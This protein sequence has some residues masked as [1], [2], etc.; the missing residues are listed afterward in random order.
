MKLSVKDFYSA[1]GLTLGLEET[2]EEEGME[3]MIKV[4]H[5]QRPGLSLAGYVKGKRNN[6]ILVFGRIEL[7]YL[8]DLKPE[9]R[10]ERL[11]G[12]VTEDNPLVI[13]ARGLTPPRELIK[14]CKELRV[15]LFKTEMHSMPLLTKLTM[16]LT[17]YFSLIDSVHGTLVEAYGIGVLIQGDSSVGKSEA[18]LGLIERGHRLISDDVVKIRT[19]EGVGV[20]G[21]GHELNKH[22]LELRGIGIVNVAHLFG[23][24]SVR[25]EVPIDIVIHLE[26]WNE[27]HYYDRVGL[28]ERF[29]EF[30][31]VKVPLYVHPVKPGRDAVLLIETTLLNH[32]LKEMGYHSAKEFNQ[33]LLEEIA[34]K[35]ELERES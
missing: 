17:D 18:A 8:R 7:N 29:T 3:R 32:R 31:G 24:V 28:E 11:Q 10:I 33:K 19:R 25:S 27:T 35:K 14:L 13:V 4:S 23:A 9:I 1:Y 6:R 34:R 12:V 5:I 26:D 15:P 22:L 21:F 2:N 30:L 20:I 16:L